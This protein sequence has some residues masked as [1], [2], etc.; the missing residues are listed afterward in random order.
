MQIVLIITLSLLIIV[1]IYIIN[2]KSIRRSIILNGTLS[3]LASFTFILLFAPDV[4]LAEAVIGSTISTMV[5]LFAIRNLRVI[6]VI[7]NPKDFKYDEI[8]GVFARIYKAE[9]YDV[10]FTSNT[11]YVGHNVHRYRHLDYYIAR[12]DEEILFF[13]RREGQDRDEIQQFLVEMTG[14]KIHE[15][16]DLS[17]IQ[18]AKH[19]K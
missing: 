1:S 16:T 2:G 4:A 15:I 6:H 7:Y 10:Q 19:E 14:K 3:L 9:S 13:S 5:L 11:E 12:K 8:Q 17:Q 18:E